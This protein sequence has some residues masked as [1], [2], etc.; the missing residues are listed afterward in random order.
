MILLK[1]DPV[2]VA[3]RRGPTVVGESLGEGGQGELRIRGDRV[4]ALFVRVE[5]V[6]VDADEANVRPAI[7]SGLKKKNIA[8]KGYN[9]EGDVLYE[10]DIVVGKVGDGG[11]GHA[12]S[13]GR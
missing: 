11:T 8:V 3:L 4:S 9:V 6:D 7:I 1:P 13:G 5:G 10:G 12:P 2:S